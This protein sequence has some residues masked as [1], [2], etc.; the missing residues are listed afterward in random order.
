VFEAAY[1]ETWKAVSSFIWIGQEI[2]KSVDAGGLVVVSGRTLVRLAVVAAALAAGA[3][4]AFSDIVFTFNSDTIGTATTFSD[5][6]SGL[7]ATFSSP[8]DPGGFEV[9]NPGPF[10]PPFSGY[11]L[12]DSLLS[13]NATNIALD[14]AFSSNLSQ[15]SMD[16]ATDGSGPFDLSA[17]EGAALVG[18]ATETGSIPTG[19]IYPQGVITFDG[20]VFDKLVLTAPSGNTPFFAIDNLDAVPEPISLLLLLTLLAIVAVPLHR[21]FKASS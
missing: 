7:T 10:A 8:A 18:M 20:A 3:V 15:V 14:V 16:F 21:K 4:P 1:S 9:G 17:Y 13:A 11:S 12:F 5:T 6:V 19:H 2:A